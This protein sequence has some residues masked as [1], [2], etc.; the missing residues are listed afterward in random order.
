MLR[1]R[2]GRGLIEFKLTQRSGHVSVGH[3]L[4][5]LGRLLEKPQ[6]ILHDDS[7]PAQLADLHSELVRH[8]V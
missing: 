8:R 3:A 7:A 4:H 5:A 6:R 2:V 1:T